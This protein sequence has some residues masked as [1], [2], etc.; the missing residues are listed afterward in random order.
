M[1]DVFTIAGSPIDPITD[2]FILIRFS[3]RLGTI[4]VLTL[5]Y[6]RAVVLPGQP[7]PW[8][9]KPAAW[10]HDGDTS[11]TGDVISATPDFDPRIGSREPRTRSTA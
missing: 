8:V 2:D 9:H 7:D 5:Q 4:P 11:F 6:G 3:E 10:L 1:S